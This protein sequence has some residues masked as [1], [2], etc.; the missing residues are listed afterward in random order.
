MWQKGQSGNPAGKP[1]GAKN[2]SKTQKRRSLAKKIQSL[3]DKNFEGFVKDY[4][5]L[6]PVERVKIYTT[7]LQYV[8]PKKQ[9]VDVKTQTELEYKEMQ[10][11]IEQ[12]PDEMASIV[13]GRMLELRAGGGDVDESETDNF[14]SDEDL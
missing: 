7:L 10:V 11:L 5:S 3:L 8:E 9:A 1:K 2:L 6:E 14:E 12:S 13:A 4:Q